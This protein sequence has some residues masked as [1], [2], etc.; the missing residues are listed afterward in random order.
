MTDRPAF[1]LL[2]DGAWFAGT[3]AR[4]I[5]PAFGEVVFTTNLTGYQETF[6]DPSYLGQI[7]VMTAPMIGNYGVNLE[8]MESERPQ[9][10]GVVVR[11]LSRHPSN[12]RCTASLDEWLSIGGI[13]VIEGVD[14]RRLTRHVRERGAMRGVVAEGRQ[15]GRELT[16]Q[17]LAS[18]SM[19][20]LDLA[21]RATVRQ[22]RSEGD[23]PHV[24][25]YDYGM[26]RNIVRMLVHSG[27]R[28]TVL[29]AETSVAE[30]RALKPDGLFLSNGPG[31]PAAVEYALGT[32]RELTGNGLPTFGICLGHQLVGLAF[33]G[34]TAKL[35]YG[36]R[37]GNHPVRDLRTGQVL[38]TTQNH[39]F[40]VVGDAGGV[41]GAPDLEVTHLNL[42]DG[43]IE[44]VRHR[45]LPL[46][47]VQYHPEA[48]PGP[49][50]AFPHFGEFLRS[51]GHNPLT[52]N[53]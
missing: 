51:I 11:E 22:P 12:W 16:A 53:T 20:G 10:S 13:P 31:D 38:I 49:H 9:I 33:G 45:T 37:G 17:L 7:V 6:T 15:P 42:N 4:P 44:G 52:D 5:D 26:K 24:I 3:T 21:S 32:I 18:P 39:G 23:G 2:E 50:D 14:T 25:A 41:P 1:V 48:S 28:V 36:H 47:A 8:D 34:A 43:T 30:A 27:C 19:N 46:F 40:A 35:P 29:P